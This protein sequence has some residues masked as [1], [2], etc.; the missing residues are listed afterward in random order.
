MSFEIHRGR[1]FAEDVVQEAAE[2]DGGKHGRSGRCHGVAYETLVSHDSTGLAGPNSLLR[3]VPDAPAFP[4]QAFCGL[5][6]GETILSKAG[7]A[8]VQNHGAADL[9]A[10][11]AA[12]FMRGRECCSNPRGRDRLAIRLRKGAEIR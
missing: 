1:V 3:S 11:A 4:I 8:V 7:D 5:L 2:L 9:G 10:A 6:L 12:G